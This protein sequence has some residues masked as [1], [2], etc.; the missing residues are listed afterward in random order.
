MSELNTYVVET[1]NA[2]VT[3]AISDNGDGGPYRATYVGA[4]RIDS[5]RK[6]DPDKPLIEKFD[7]KKED[8]HFDVLMAACHKEIAERGGEIISIKKMPIEAK[9]IRPSH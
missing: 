2:F 1:T 3:L 5:S 7:G 6:I 4:P 8:P 9:D